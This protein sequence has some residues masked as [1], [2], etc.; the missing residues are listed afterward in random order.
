MPSIYE[1]LLAAGVPLDSHESDLY[2]LV[3]PESKAIIDA[4]QFK[5]NV[6]TFVSQIDNKHWY[7]IPFAYQPYWEGRRGRP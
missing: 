2:A 3:T 5:C 6:T 1:Q 4:Y 7:D